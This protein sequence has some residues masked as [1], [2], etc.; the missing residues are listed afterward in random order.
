MFMSL[1]LL[2]TLCRPE[3]DHNFPMKLVLDSA[4]FIKFSTWMSD[5]VSASVLQITVENF[6]LS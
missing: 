1:I 5:S 2:R 6:P 4:T 3:T